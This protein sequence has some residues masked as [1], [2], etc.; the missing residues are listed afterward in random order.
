[1]RLGII[2]LGKMGGNMALRLIGKGHEVVV[3]DRN[4]ELVSS[5]A[6]KG[7]LPS[8]D[9]AEFVS[10][11]SP[12]RVAWIMVPSGNPVD[13]TIDKLTEVME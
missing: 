6:G 10:K 12:R 13:D 8:G 9:I 1:M 4:P 3:Y 5:F 7:A 11:L 2:G